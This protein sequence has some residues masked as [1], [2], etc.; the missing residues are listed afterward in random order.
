MFC[1]NISINLLELG[2]S[3]HSQ[4]EI[5]LQRVKS[6]K[7]V[8]DN[9]ARIRCLHGSRATPHLLECAS[10]MFQIGASTVSL[11]GRLALLEVRRIGVGGAED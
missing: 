1:I 8:R 2:Q 9:F 10:R 4:R 11:G 5:K 7:N 3:R 6:K